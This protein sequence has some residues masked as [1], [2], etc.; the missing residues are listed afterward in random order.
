M[1]SRAGVS[2]EEPC[3]T[4]G[5]LAFLGSIGGV[6]SPLF[7]TMSLQ[8]G[9]SAPTHC[10]S[11]VGNVRRSV[12]PSAA[13]CWRPPGLAGTGRVQSAPTRPAE[14]SGTSRAAGT[15][16][17][18]GLSLV[19]AKLSRGHKIFSRTQSRSRMIINYFNSAFAKGYKNSHD[20]FFS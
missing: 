6:H 17:H 2:R 19:S 3:L 12:C 11:W 7:S 9:P 1:M 13:V 14:G 20:I 16:C 15:P 18:L 5:S 8:R 4:L 10:A